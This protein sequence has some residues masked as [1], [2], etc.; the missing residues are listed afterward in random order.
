[1]HTPPDYAIEW[2]IRRVEC[3]SVVTRAV[4]PSLCCYDDDATLFLAV[5]LIVLPSFRATI[6]Y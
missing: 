2:Q 6:F 4:L 1:M 5:S 3:A